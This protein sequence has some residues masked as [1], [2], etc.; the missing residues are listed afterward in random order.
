MFETGTRLKHPSHLHSYSRFLAAFGLGYAGTQASPGQTVAPK[1]SSFLSEYWNQ[2]GIYLKIN[3]VNRDH[4]HALVE[5]ERAV[6]KRT[7][8]R[9]LRK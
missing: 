9:T 2:K 7:L 4:V 3:Y 6:D 8:F 1:L 5:V